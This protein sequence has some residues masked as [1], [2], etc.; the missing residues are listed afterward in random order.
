MQSHCEFSILE[1]N[2]LESERNVSKVAIKV[3]LIS[4]S[5]EKRIRLCLQLVHLG[6][7]ASIH[8]QLVTVKVHLS[9]GQ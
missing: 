4:S 5:L 7:E 2:F 9:E 8:L 1:D 3:A 6:G